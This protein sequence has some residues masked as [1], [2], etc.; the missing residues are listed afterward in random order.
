MSSRR[1]A[2]R[3]A[4]DEMDREA[5]R[6][7]RGRA[8]LSRADALRERQAIESE[9]NQR[10][11]MPSQGDMVRAM[12]SLAAA[13]GRQRLVPDIISRA[14]VE[15]RVIRACLTHAASPRVRGPECRVAWPATLVEWADLVAR[16]ENPDNID[17]EALRPRFQPTPADIADELVALG[18][19]L[20]L[21]TPPAPISSRAPRPAP[22]SGAAARHSRLSDW[23]I[24]F[25]HALG[26]GWGE[27]GRRMGG[28]PRDARRSYDGAIDQCH[29]AANLEA[30]AKAKGQRK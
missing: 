21:T 14:D 28:T 3:R 15:R 16:G 26:W 1:S 11:A 12:R 27:V 17:S 23:D 30:A 6:E 8:A 10:A 25:M 22:R 20:H 18:W 7:E 9:R 5:R 2:L 24:V 13:G 19:M 29:R 4:L